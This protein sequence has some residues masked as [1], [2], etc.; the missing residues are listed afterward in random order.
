V[1]RL[2]AR[3]ATLSQIPAGGSAPIR[4]VG[5]GV[6]EICSPVRG[7]VVDDMGRDTAYAEQ[8]A[9]GH[10]IEEK[11]PDKVE[12]GHVCHDAALVE[13]SPGRSFRIYRSCLERGSALVCR[14]DSIRR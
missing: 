9:G 6:A 1:C 14:L 12:T 5:V 4:G 3:H 11:E 13:D 10:G 8:Q 2:A 7:D